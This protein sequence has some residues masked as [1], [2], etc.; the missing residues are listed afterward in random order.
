[1]GRGTA[2]DFTN[3]WTEAFLRKGICNMNLTP[4][5]WN[6]LD[7]LGKQPREQTVQFSNPH[8]ISSARTAA[9]SW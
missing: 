3:R 7:C 8:C 4:T 2:L 1:M 5:T 6:R 9:K